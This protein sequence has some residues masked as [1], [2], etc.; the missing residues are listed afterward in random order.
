MERFSFNEGKTYE[1]YPEIENRPVYYRNRYGTQLAA[2]IFFPEHFD[3]SKNYPAVIVSHPHGGVKEQSG[4]LYA[5]ELAKAGFIG[6][7]IDL[8][9]NGGSG[10]SARHIS[11][12]E[13][14]VEDIQAA[15]DYLGTRPFVLRDGIGLVG[16]C[17]SGSFAVAAASTDMRIKAVAAVTMY[18]I[19]EN[20]R[21]MFGL[22]DAEAR[23]EMLRHAGEQ[24][25]AEYEGADT[26]FMME[27]PRVVTEE[28]YYSLDPV[29]REFFDYYLN[30]RRGRHQYSVGKIALNSLAA[31]FNFDPY[32]NMDLLGGR[33]ILVV[34][35]TDAHSRVYSEECYAKAYEPKEMYW[36]EGAGHCDLYDDKTK[37]PFTKLADFFGA[38]LRK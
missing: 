16:V 33:P 9:S 8:S 28:I 27:F 4:G 32:I 35:G 17:A 30:N 6:F 19:G 11:T 1:V 34:C 38:N 23:K 13:G 14:H 5:Q 2:D 15:V 26:E 22:R 3:P 10:G 7:A 21:T 25:W 20:Y 36:V 12:P 29:S 37:I 31:L 24:R 18:N